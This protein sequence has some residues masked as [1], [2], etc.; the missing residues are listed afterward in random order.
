MRRYEGVSVLDEPHQW[1]VER[2][3]VP[4]VET[5]WVILTVWKPLCSSSSDLL[6]IVTETQRVPRQETFAWAATMRDPFTADE[7][8][9]HA[10][11]RPAIRMAHVHPE[12]AVERG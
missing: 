4:L 1:V 6:Q 2:P 11:D 12:V 8:A 5:V 3:P 9:H 7:F 10:H